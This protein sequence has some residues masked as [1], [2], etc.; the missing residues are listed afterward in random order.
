MRT[1]VKHS[2]KIA[3]LALLLAASSG[4]AA[5]QSLVQ[6]R[7]KLDIESLESL[8]KK[9]EHVVDV[10]IDENFMSL[11]ARV[12]TK[13][14]DPEAKKIAD[15]VAGFKGVYVRS[16]GFSGEGQW[17]ESD[18]AGIRAQLK[19]PGWSRIVNVM[20]RKDGQNVEVYLMT[21]PASLGGLAVIATQPNELTVVNI[22][23]RIDI[24]KLA[25][26]EGHLG[27]PDLDIRIGG[28]DRDEDRKPEVKRAAPAAK[29]P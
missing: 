23:G 12:V 11:A 28:S 29:K 4:A 27:I 26:L 16:F 24:D 21:D 14:K 13:S 18:I 25:D 9:A 15:I 7:S 2:L 17:K 22:V 3:S 19:G 10:T 5:A 20:S 6:P 8:S 1:F